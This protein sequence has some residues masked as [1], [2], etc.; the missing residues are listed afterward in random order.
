M[1]IRWLLI[2]LFIYL[3]IK[4]IKG[5]KTKN[6]RKSPFPFDGFQQGSTKQRK[7]PNLD[8]IEEAEFED[9]TEKEKKT[10]NS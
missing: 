3:V 4:L 5:P 1:L 10:D 2:A 6:K 8:Q 7:R 9:I